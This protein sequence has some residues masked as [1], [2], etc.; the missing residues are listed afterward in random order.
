[1]GEGSGV[2]VVVAR[3]KEKKKFHEL[4][5]P[6]RKMRIK[7]EIYQSEPG[8]VGFVWNSLVRGKNIFIKN[9]PTTSCSLPFRKSFYDSRSKAPL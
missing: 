7:F 9:I 4:P 8:L 1:M 6:S 2:A 5:N 3:E